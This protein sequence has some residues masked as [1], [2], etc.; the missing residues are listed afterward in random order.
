[1][2]SKL[3]ELNQRLKEL[4]AIEM[5][6]VKEERIRHDTTCP[7]CDGNGEISNKY[8]GQFMDT[9]RYE[10]GYCVKGYISAERYAIYKIEEE[11]KIEE[12]KSYIRKARAEREKQRIMLERKLSDCCTF[13]G[14]HTTTIKNIFSLGKQK[15]QHELMCNVYIP[16]K[17]EETRHICPVCG[18]FSFGTHKICEGHHSV[19]HNDDLGPK[20]AY[21]G[22]YHLCTVCGGPVWPPYRRDKYNENKHHV[23][24]LHEHCYEFLEYLF[25][26]NKLSEEVF[27]HKTGVNPPAEN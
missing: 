13:C 5:K 7:F 8:F 20:C 19:R 9:A 17:P 21:C 16:P 15:K 6:A 12:T 10:C 3:E 22:E 24:D 14:K 26:I 27:L 11:I 4:R 1:M 25:R 18:E 2:N 23:F